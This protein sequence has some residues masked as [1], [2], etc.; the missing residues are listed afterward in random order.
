MITISFVK[1][2]IFIKLVV[3]LFTLSFIFWHCANNW[4]RGERRKR[5]I[6]LYFFRLQPIEILKPFLY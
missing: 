3:P 5:W 1:T 4:C 2:E 6:D